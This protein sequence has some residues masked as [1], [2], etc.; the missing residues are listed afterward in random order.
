LL[1]GKYLLDE[2][3]DEINEAAGEL[4]AKAAK[5]KTTKRKR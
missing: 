2:Y 5:K 1:A 3:M 4:K